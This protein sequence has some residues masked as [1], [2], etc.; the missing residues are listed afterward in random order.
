MKAIC[1]KDENHKLFITTAHEVHDWVVD[2]TGDFV[3]DVECIEVSADPNSG[4]CWTCKICGA[5]AT[6]TD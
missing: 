4:N 5:E 2:E 3:E 6:V 1:P